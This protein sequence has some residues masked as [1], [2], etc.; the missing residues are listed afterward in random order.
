VTDTVVNRFFNIVRDDGN[1]LYELD[2][3]NDD[4]IF[5]LCCLN[6]NAKI[7]QTENWLFV[8]INISSMSMSLGNTDA[9]NKDLSW[10]KGEGE[11]VIYKRPKT[12]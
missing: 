9:Q 2:Q 12:A 8:P 10:S 3:R 5:I 7:G 6:S 4:P 1:G 11:P